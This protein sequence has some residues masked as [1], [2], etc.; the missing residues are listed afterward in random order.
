M[1]PSG[2]DETWIS[3]GCVW[4]SDGGHINKLGSGRQYR[5]NTRADEMEKTDRRR[6]LFSV[7]EMFS[8]SLE[9][10]YQLAPLY[11]S[12]CL[13][14]LMIGICGVL[15]PKLDYVIVLFQ[16]YPSDVSAWQPHLT[17]QLHQHST[18][19]YKNPK[20]KF[21]AFWVFHW[22]WEFMLNLC[23]CLSARF[24]KINS[25]LSLILLKI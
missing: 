23:I 5:E 14:Y 21:N 3:W 2:L 6:C 12:D 9:H 18:L 24:G 1:K 16:N 19:N 25:N 13:W 15:P 7:Q 17:V 20:N 11:K 8:L 10:I 22:N 4:W